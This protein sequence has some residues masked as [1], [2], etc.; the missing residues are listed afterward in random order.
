MSPLSPDSAAPRAVA[1]DPAATGLLPR[2]ARAQILRAVLLLC[3]AQPG[4]ARAESDNR[5]AP[6]RFGFSRQIF[7]EVNETDARA[8]LKVWAQTLVQEDGLT[9]DPDLQIMNSTAA[10][11][12]ALDAGKVDAISITPVEFWELKRQVRFGPTILLGSAQGSTK[13][14]FLLLVLAENPASEPADLRGSTLNVLQGS[15]ATLAEA[16]IESVL[17]EQNLGVLSAFWSSVRMY[18]RQSQVVLPVFF[19]KAGA[20]VTTSESFRLMSELNPQIGRQLKILARSPEFAVAPLCFRS[21]FHSPNLN[22]FLADLS[23]VTQTVAGRQTLAM[24]HSDLIVARPLSDM[25]GV[26]ALLDRHQELL[27]AYRKGAAT[28]PPPDLTE[29]PKGNRP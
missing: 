25:D 9:V 7:S 20:C 19:K 17:L 8:A 11:R 3:L 18:N 13:E 21:D 29:E 22:Q 24:F 2:L 10:I 12:M 5:P 6:M 27:A 28:A 4:V 23:K 14:Q 26:C 15:R 16:W 1:L